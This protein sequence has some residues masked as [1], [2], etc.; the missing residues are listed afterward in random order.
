[1]SSSYPTLS[2]L[3]FERKG[4]PLSAG[5]ATEN[6]NTGL[7][8]LPSEVLETIL[9]SFATWGDLAKLA[10]VQSGWRSLLSDSASMCPEAKWD[11]AQSLL[12]GTNGLRANPLLAVRHMM[13]LANIDVDED[14]LPRKTH[15]DRGDEPVQTSYFAPAMREIADC[16]LLGNGV[17]QSGP[18]GLAWLAAAFEFGNDIT[19]AHRLGV[20]Y[21]RDY[22]Q[23]N[24]IEVD[25]YAAATWFESGAEAGHPDSMAELALCYELGCGRE[26]S[27]EKALDWYM[28]AAERGNLTAKFSVAE[29]FEEARGVPQSDEEAC[30]WYYKAAIEGCDDSKLA[31]QRLHEIARI[32]VPGVG[33][34]FDA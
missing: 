33:Q 5:A 31:L 18:K 7:V 23:Y 26:Q 34:L 15:R 8:E 1:M 32:V 11:L 28:K 10:T 27:D 29:A 14:G 2:P 3:Y 9:S 16:Y 6:D 12:R 24:D 30:L 25:V 20:I 4:A 22:A 21:E 17:E 19:A 13:E